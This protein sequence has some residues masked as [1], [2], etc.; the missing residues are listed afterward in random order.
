LYDL[1]QGTEMKSGKKHTENAEIFRAAMSGVQPLKRDNRLAKRP[2]KPA[3]I[4]IQFQLDEAAVLQ[5]LLQPVDDPAAIETGEELLF[6]RPGYPPRLLRQLRRGFFSSSDS[7]DLHQMT[8]KIAR[9][10]LLQF[11]V[12]ANRRGLGCVRVIH[13]K[14]LRSQGP[15]VLK[16]MAQKILR[17]HP[18]VIAFASCRPVNGG[19]GAVDILL[20]ETS[21]PTQ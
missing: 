3:P 5:E 14:G 18:S 17:K 16:L 2:P 11:I 6:L 20:K 1:K 10:V 15:P 4:P 9:E 21:S 7:I 8:E 12:A 13:G 19:T